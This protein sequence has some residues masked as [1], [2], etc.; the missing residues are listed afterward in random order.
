MESQDDRTSRIDEFI[1]K[2]RK[3]L[4]DLYDVADNN[5]E[6]A[7]ALLQDLINM[8]IDKILEALDY[9]DQ[10]QCKN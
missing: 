10:Q 4:L 9:S 6:R 8:K 1:Q 2:N 7:T 3:E 5:G